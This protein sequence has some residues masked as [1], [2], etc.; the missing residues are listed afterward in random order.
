MRSRTWDFIAIAAI[1]VALAF[2][3]FFVRPLLG[4]EWG[5]TL[6]SIAIVLIVVAGL[7]LFVK[8]LRT[9]WS[10]TQNSAEASTVEA[11]SPRPS[12]SLGVGLVVILSIIG[13]AAVLL[14]LPLLPFHHA[15][16][17]APAVATAVAVKTVPQPTTP[18]D[19]YLDVLKKTLTRAQVAGRYERYTIRPNPVNRLT[20]TVV[21]P[22]LHTQ[23]YD[24]V[25]LRASDP[26]AYM[27]D[28]G[29]NS[30]RLDDGETMVGLLQLDNMQACIEDV[31]RRNVPGD[32][33]EAGAWRG[34]LTILMRGVLK[35]YGDT[36][37]KVFVADSFEGL[38]SADAAKDA[39]HY[40]AGQMAV[41]L[42]EVKENFAAYGLLDDQVV[43]LK[44]FFSQ[45]LPNAP[46]QKLAIF[47]ANGDLYESTTDAL[48][49]LYPKL[50]VGGYAIFDDYV[51]EPAV[52]KAIDEY[53]AA[54]G[55][56]EPIRQI[57][58]AAV[59]WQR[60]K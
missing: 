19:L 56:T 57:D 43:F 10:C 31:L 5:G 37:R 2:L 24:L 49:N 12:A 46:I 25:G 27:N 17:A 44:G 38:P 30:A 28:G 36:N 20:L 55:I 60:E 42:D 34:G 26:E 23:G 9:V 53:R 35:A 54:H 7:P 22:M 29:E 50:S 6:L 1:V 21:E 51:E 4:W 47:R 18:Q 40:Y 59:Y 13:C 41:S 33:I 39:T 3:L 52:K 14:A 48:N 45:T 32:L 15:P 16:S 58:N 8:G 11:E